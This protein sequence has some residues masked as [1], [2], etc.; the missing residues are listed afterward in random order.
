MASIVVPY[1]ASPLSNCSIKKKQQQK[2][3]KKI[4]TS[5]VIAYGMLSWL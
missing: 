4:D 3:T 5:Q 2:Q 1:I